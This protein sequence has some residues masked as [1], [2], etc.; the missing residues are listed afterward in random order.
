MDDGDLPASPWQGRGLGGNEDD[1]GGSRARGDRSGALDGLADSR[2]TGV[3][4]VAL[5]I[6]DVRDI[7][8]STAASRWNTEHGK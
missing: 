5:D 1:V 3:V 4:E 6:S 7:I 8:S 2:S